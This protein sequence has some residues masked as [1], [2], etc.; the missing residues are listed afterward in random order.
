MTFEGEP[1][2]KNWLVQEFFFTWSVVQAIFLGLCI[3]FFGHSCCMIFLTVKALQ[4]FFLSNLPLLPPQRSN[5][6]PL[7]RTYKTFI[8]K[9]RATPVLWQGSHSIFALDA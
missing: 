9:S 4:K 8:K 2:W 1:G 6:P 3:H 5:G 7:R